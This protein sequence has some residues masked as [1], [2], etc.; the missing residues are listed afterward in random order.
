MRQPQQPPGQENSAPSSPTPVCSGVPF[1][2]DARQPSRVRGGQRFSP[3]AACRRR[4]AAVVT[5]LLV[6]QSKVARCGRSSC[7]NSTCDR[8]PQTPPTS[9]RLVKWVTPTC[10]SHAAPPRVAPSPTQRLASNRTRV[11]VG[12]GWGEGEMGHAS[13][14]R[15]PLAAPQRQPPHR[16][17][18][19]PI[20]PRA[21]IFQPRRSRHDRPRSGFRNDPECERSDTSGAALRR[22]PKGGA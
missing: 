16:R 9:R 17:C 7:L 4:G 22:H 10:G 6:C 3:S 12:M 14:Q 1:E 11:T 8:P 19:L 21:T 15:I 2:R 13:A 18:R 5:D 20:S